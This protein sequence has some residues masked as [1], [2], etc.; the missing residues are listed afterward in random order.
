M[1]GFV[2]NAL[3]VEVHFALVAGPDDV[4]ELRSPSPELRL[5]LG[6]IGFVTHPAFLGALDGDDPKAGQPCVIAD[7]AEHIPNV[8]EVSDDHTEE[9]SQKLLQ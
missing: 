4:L 5:E 9:S 6:A 1:L 7:R 8:F 2:L 3:P